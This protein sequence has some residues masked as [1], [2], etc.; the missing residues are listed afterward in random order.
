MM[1][2][3]YFGTLIG[4][5]KFSKVKIYYVNKDSA[6]FVAEKGLHVITPIYNYSP[7]FSI[8]QGK[9]KPILKNSEK[10]KG[11]KV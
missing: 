7:L 11:A 6:T 8:Y 9:K 5:G 3:E 1:D 2:F 4:C 10:G